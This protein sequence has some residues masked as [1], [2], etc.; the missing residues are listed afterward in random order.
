MIPAPPGA[1]E[2]PA[3]QPRG[4][5]VLMNRIR[6]T[7]LTLLS[8]LATLACGGSSTSGTASPSTDASMPPI[9]FVHGNG[10]YSAL[11]I[12][13][14]WRFESN[15]YPRNRLFT[16][17]FPAPTARDDNSVAQSNRSS[18]DDQRQQLA[19]KVDAVLKA[20][21]APK[22]ALVGQSRGG[23]P[24]RNYLKNGS[25][26]SKVGWAITAGTPNH[27][28]Y[29][30][31]GGPNSEFNGAAPFLAQLNNPS[32]VVP[33]VKFL[34]LRSDTNDKYAQPELAPGRSSGITYEG[35]ALNG[36]TNVVLPGADHRE[37]GYS[38]KAFSQMFQFI[39]G[40]APATTDIKPEASPKLTGTIGGYDNHAP[41]NQGVPGVKVT[42]YEIDTATGARRGAAV[43]DATTGAD[44]GWGPLNAK[45]AASYEF[46]VAAAG[47][48]VRHFF[49]SPF[50]RS[51]AL[52]HMRLFE[53]AAPAPGKSAIIFTRP[54]GYI[55]NTRDQH[56]LDGKPVP[57][58]PDGVPTSAS[59]RVEIEGP[60]RAVPSALNGEKLTVRAIPGEIVYAEFSY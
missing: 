1:P 38:P 41:T 48:P 14:L 19:T 44:G 27:G 2:A 53:D 50:P 59:F 51:S 43:L 20:T 47:Q 54:R 32:E 15:G 17:D 21:G 9:L 46:V 55:S 11:W 3:Q 6:L 45:P 13:T 56:S 37:T 39:T 28:V 18:T 12:T 25:G 40:K 22:L 24:I 10:D 34:T 23:Y 49:R 26:A 29:S 42:I 16:I 36:A 5:E 31:P 57:K 7:A 33:G 60:E 30:I 58:V 35:P 4:M 8:M 52:I